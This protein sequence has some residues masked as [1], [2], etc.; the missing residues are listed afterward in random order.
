[1]A[2]GISHRRS[3]M[4][5]AIPWYTQSYS[6]VKDKSIAGNSTFLFLDRWTGEQTP[7]LAYA[8]SNTSTTV[9]LALAGSQTVLITFFADRNASM[10]PYHFTRPLQS[11]MGLRFNSHQVLTPSVSSAS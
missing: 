6:Q 11:M 2:L 7:L 1:M 3:L 5:S 9:S 8:Q 10:T 4:G